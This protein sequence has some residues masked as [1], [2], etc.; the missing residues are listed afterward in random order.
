MVKTPRANAGAARDTGSIPGAGRSTGAKRSTGIGNGSPPQYSCL[1]NPTGRGVW[2]ATA[3]SVAKS[4]HDWA[5]AADRHTTSLVWREWK[6]SVSICLYLHNR[7][8]EKTDKKLTTEISWREERNGWRGLGGRVRLHKCPT[9][10]SA[11]VRWENM[12]SAQNDTWHWVGTEVFF[13]WMS[14]TLMLFNTFSPI[15]GSA[16]NR[17]MNSLRPSVTSLR[18]SC[19]TS[20]W[21]WCSVAQSCPTLCDPKEG[22]AAPQASLSFSV[23]Q[24]LLK[25][26]STELA[27]PSNHLIFYRPL[28]LSSIF[29]SIR[30]IFQWVGS[31][32]QVAKVL[33]LQHQSL[34]WI[35]RVPFL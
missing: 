1:E 33:E 30:V 15:Q 9:S 26:M 31:S 32:H 25:F 22:S 21:W 20:S 12:S 10:Q 2:W 4:Q 27:M 6:R 28:R 24:S 18:S 13:E 35:F 14:N 16:P 3:Y 11:K 19:P 34:Q 7:S 17:V 29:P 23:S 5:S 8:L